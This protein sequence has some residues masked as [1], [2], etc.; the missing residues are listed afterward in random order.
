MD[1]AQG[2][3][4]DGSGSG[5]VMEIARVLQAAN[6]SF[7]YTVLIQTYCAEEQ[8][9]TVPPVTGSGTAAHQRR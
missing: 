2:A 6:A 5:L 8:V 3:N 9:R 1:T 7:R 4:D